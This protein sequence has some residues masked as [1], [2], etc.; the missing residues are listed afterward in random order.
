[1]M[2]RAFSW[3]PFAYLGQISFSIYLIHFTFLNTFSA[4][5]F[6]RVIDHFSYNL[7]FAITFIISMVPLFVLSHYYMKYIDQGAIKLAR[8]IEKSIT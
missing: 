7:A 5:L 6:S 3:Q 4:F 2:Q 1:M 8:N